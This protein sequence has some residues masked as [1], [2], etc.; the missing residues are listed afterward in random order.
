MNLYNIDM[1]ISSNY[2]SWGYCYMAENISDRVGSRIREYRKLAGLTQESLALSAN[3]G[4]SFLGDV[5]RG[6]KKPSIDSLEKILSVLNI[7]FGEFFDFTPN[8]DSPA[9]K[10]LNME[11]HRLSN[12]EI[13]AIYNIVKEIVSLRDGKK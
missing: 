12:T 4:V 5:E 10:K 6:T 9:L 3:I 11:L 2:R 8:L 1:E 7:S 13:E